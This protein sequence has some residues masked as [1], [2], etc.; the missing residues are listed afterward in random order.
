MEIMNEKDRKKI[1][2]ESRK[3]GGISLRRQQLRVHRNG[4]KFPITKAYIDDELL[5]P[6]ISYTLILLPEVNIAEK[7]SISLV[8]F[9]RKR[10]P[11]MYYSYPE[12]ALNDKEKEKIGEVMI[13]AAKDGFFVYQSS[14][15]S[16][17]NYYFEIYSEWARGN[18]ELLM[19][20]V[21]LNTKINQAIEEVIQAICIDFT[22]H[23]KEDR[24]L[25]KALYIK[26]LESFSDEEQS[27]IK[28]TSED[29]QNKL[30][31]FYQRVNR[32]IIKDFRKHIITVS[33]EIDKKV[34]LN[35]IAQ[36]ITGAEF[37]PERFP[38]LVMK[39]KDP[40][41]SIILFST[42]KMVITDLIKATEAEQVVDQVIKKVGKIG[43]KI[44]NP[45]ISIQITK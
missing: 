13:Q 6:E 26:Q 15:L 33:I 18:K 14:I 19:L 25:F 7:S 38:G 34:D 8:Y 23:L 42:G 39:T 40:R 36:K 35:Q 12:D 2:D 27:A 22:S 9:Q 37:N 28:Q 20:S 44:T 41:A 16:S 31:E 32:L 24:D 10:G 45:K 1:I 17:L 5:D 11:M 4:A 43:I 3:F 30:E 29:L 21:I